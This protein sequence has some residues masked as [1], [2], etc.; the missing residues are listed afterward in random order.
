M[1]SIKCPKCGK[2]IKSESS[3]CLFCGSTL[4]NFNSDE[5]AD[6]PESG[7]EA[8]EKKVSQVH[9]VA[10]LDNPKPIEKPSPIMTGTK[11]ITRNK[12]MPQPQ[13]QAPVPPA[14]VA[15]T[16]EEELVEDEEY[17]EDEGNFDES[18]YDERDGVDDE[19]SAEEEFDDQDNQDEYM[20]DDETGSDE[21]PLDDEE[22]FLRLMQKASEKEQPKKKEPKKKDREK[23]LLE[24]TIRQVA[25]KVQENIGDLGKEEK[26][27]S[28]KKRNED[29]GSKKKVH[30]DLILDEEDELE[31]DPSE[32]LDDEPDEDPEEP[33]I[34]ISYYNNIMD[35]VDAKI[36]GIT[37]ENV[38]HTIAVV[39]IVT[40]IIVAMIYC[41]VL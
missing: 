18:G 37:K 31:E 27:F 14:P 10:S 22:A 17:E 41:I 21:E 11:E 30:E 15:K 7:A 34:D 25:G 2:F 38:I 4:R 26:R 23:S 39:A 13:K 8:P 35:A 32:L 1:A 29:V 36:S 9:R 16:Y 12:P 3:Y 20:E 33:Q 19:Y 40:I 5:G 28:R 6:A 24:S